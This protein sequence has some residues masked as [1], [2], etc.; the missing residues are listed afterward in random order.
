M[1]RWE[2]RAKPR[3]DIWPIVDSAPLS[4]NG[5]PATTGDLIWDKASLNPSGPCLVREDEGAL[6]P[7][8]IFLDHAP[9]AREVRQQLLSLQPDEPPVIEAEA[10]VRLSVAMIQLLLSAA[11][12]AVMAGQGMTIINPSFAFT[13]AFRTFGFAEMTEPFTVEYQ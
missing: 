11:K 6:R 12:Q 4:I 13:L 1:S 8:T 10:V 9:S 7:R 3:K 2:I 5:D